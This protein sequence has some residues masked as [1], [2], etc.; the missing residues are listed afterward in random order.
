M[1]S[2]PQKVASNI[3]G[4]SLGKA[5]HGIQPVS[6]HFQ[7]SNLANK[8]KNKFSSG[9]DA[10]LNTIGKLSPFKTKDGKVDVTAGLTGGAYGNLPNTPKTNQLG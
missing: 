9:N 7:A 8:H 4:S 10:L 2:V 1:N 5:L 3:A 6:P